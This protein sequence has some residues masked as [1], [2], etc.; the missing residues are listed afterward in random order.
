[1]G[2][3]VLAFA[4]GVVY[5]SFVRASVRVCEGLSDLKEQQVWNLSGLDFPECARVWQ[6]CSL[7]TGRR[8]STSPHWFGRRFPLD[9]PAH[10]RAE[11]H[12]LCYLCLPPPL[13]PPV[14]QAG[15]KGSGVCFTTHL[16]AFPEQWAA[17]DY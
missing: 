12:T 15:A 14:S 3:I 7:F 11:A 13:G 17:R 10:A 6:R 9:S 8:V 16:R 1:M 4:F 2:E 5:E